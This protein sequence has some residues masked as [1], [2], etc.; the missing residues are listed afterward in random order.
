MLASA[1]Q[2]PSTFSPPRSIFSDL[3]FLKTKAKRA[4]SSVNTFQSWHL[5]PLNQESENYDALPNSAWLLCFCF[6]VFFFF[7][8]KVILDHSQAPSFIYCLG[9]VGFLFC[10][11]FFAITVELST[12]NRDGMICKAK[13]I[14]C[15]VLYGKCLDTHARKS[16]EPVFSQVEM[17]REDRTKINDLARYPATGYPAT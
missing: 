13:H 4:Q 14:Y 7:L 2:K 17:C 8:N 11:V 3:L 16:R 9:L 15:L 1:F 5:N 10:F 12:W 6:W